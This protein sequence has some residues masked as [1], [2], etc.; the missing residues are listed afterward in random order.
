M[1]ALVNLITCPKRDFTAILDDAFVAA[2]DDDDP[3]LD[4]V[5]DVFLEDDVLAAS[6]SLLRVLTMVY[7][8]ELTPCLG[9]S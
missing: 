5:D 8:R 4:A 1:T 7:P 2:T 9:F 6:A 3:A